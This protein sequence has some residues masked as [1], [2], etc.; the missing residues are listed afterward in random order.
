MS[1][2]A[3]QQ[4]TPETFQAMINAW[5][6]FVAQHVEVTEIGEDWSH[7]VV[8][9]ALEADNANFF[10]TAFGGTMFAMVDPFLAILTD[11]Q[12]GDGY[13][14]WDKA[15]EIDF[16]RPGRTSVT[17]R[18]EVTADVVDEIRA[19]TAGGDKHLRWF[20]IPLL[21][22]SGETVAL[23]RRQLYIRRRPVDAN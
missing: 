14:V 1:T 5:P 20:E 11:R 21:D 8:R 17:A 15:A 22:E 23:Q 6:P 10:G 7:V 18:I 16:V 19:A 13:A 9:M 2:H 12:L 4:F 3:E